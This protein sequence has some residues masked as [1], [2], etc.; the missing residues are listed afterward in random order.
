MSDVENAFDAA[1]GGG[2]PPDPDP[3]ESRLARMQGQARRRAREV[4]LAQEEVRHVVP[5]IDSRYL[6]VFFLFFLMA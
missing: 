2:H 5:L 3:V 6:V 4:R 1:L